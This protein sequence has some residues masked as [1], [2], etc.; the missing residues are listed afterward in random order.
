MGYKNVGKTNLV[1]MI[2]NGRFSE[3]YKATMIT[4]EYKFTK[5]IQGMEKTFNLMDASGEERFRTVNR[6]FFKN[7]D[8]VLLVYDIT[9]R[10]SFTEVISVYE[11]LYHHLREHTVFVIGNKMD[12]IDQQEV[13]EQEGRKYAESIN[14]FFVL[15]SCSTGMGITEIF[16]L[17]EIDKYKKSYE[18][19]VRLDCTMSR[20]ILTK[21][22]CL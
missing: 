19:A 8:I 6:I 12:L 3:E 7:A 13:T 21:K 5:T 4:S 11:S 18:S 14:A 2:T 9:N 10:Q 17:I 15:I 22:K 1:T 20:P 16:D